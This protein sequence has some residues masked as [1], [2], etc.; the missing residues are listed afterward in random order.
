MKQTPQFNFEL[1]GKENMA[2][3]QG[4]QDGVGGLPISQPSGLGSDSGSSSGE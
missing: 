4:P 2:G 3:D 1:S